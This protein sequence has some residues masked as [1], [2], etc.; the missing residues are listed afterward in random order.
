MGELQNGVL[1]GP[2]AEKV[3]NS[4]N[5]NS[6]PH[7]ELHRDVRAT[8]NLT[9]LSPLMPN[10]FHSICYRYVKLGPKRKYI[11]FRMCSDSGSFYNVL[12]LAIVRKYDMLLDSN[13]KGLSATDVNGGTLT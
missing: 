6:L 9:S 3:R 1:R 7:N 5:I 2:G 11:K 12:P 4:L 10:S 8:M 13:H